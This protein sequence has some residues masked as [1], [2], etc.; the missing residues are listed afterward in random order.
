[1]VHEL[2]DE[3]ETEQFWKDLIKQMLTYNHE[4][5]PSIHDLLIQNEVLLNCAK[6]N[7]EDA[8]QRRLALGLSIGLDF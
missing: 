8:R 2:I 4:S 3:L 7:L 5:R 1:M 6:K